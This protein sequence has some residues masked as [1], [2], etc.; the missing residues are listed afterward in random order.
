RSWTTSSI[1]D[2][3]MEHDGLSRQISGQD[4]VA[5]FARLVEWHGGVWG[6]RS[7]RSPVEL[8]DGPSARELHGLTYVGSFALTMCWWKVN[9]WGS[10]GSIWALTQWFWALPKVCRRVKFSITW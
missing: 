6:G 7:C 8:T 3:R 5:G 10:F 9:T 2:P 4:D 1:V